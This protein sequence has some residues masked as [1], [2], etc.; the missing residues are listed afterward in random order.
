MLFSSCLTRYGTEVW[1]PGVRSLILY[2]ND[3]DEGNEIEDHRLK[4]KGRPKKVKIAENYDGIMDK[5]FEDNKKSIRK[6][7]KELGKNLIQPNLT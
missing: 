7:A 4:N 6:I 2:F 5:S 1:H 3:I